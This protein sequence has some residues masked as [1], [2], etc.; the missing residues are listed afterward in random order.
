MQTWL[1]P[2]EFTC[3]Q[4]VCCFHVCTRLIPLMVGL[5]LFGRKQKNSLRI[6]RFLVI[7]KL[8]Y[9][10]VPDAKMFVNMHVN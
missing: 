6:H 4:F 7:M 9:D 5:S 3:F 1:L 2:L 8:V 10:E